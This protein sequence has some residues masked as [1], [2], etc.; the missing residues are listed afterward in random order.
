MDDK[1]HP[2]N[3]REMLITDTVIGLVGYAITARMSSAPLLTSL[4]GN[5]VFSH[6][7]GTLAHISLVW[8]IPKISHWKR[9]PRWTG[10]SLILALDATVGCVIAAFVLYLLGYYGIGSVWPQFQQAYTVSLVITLI[11]GLTGAITDSLR[12]R[13]EWA[14]RQRE[15]AMQLATEARL[16]SLESKIHPHFLFN[17]LNSISSL[18]REDPDHAERLIERMAALLRF[19][20]DATQLGLVTL[21]QEMDIVRGYLEIEKAR[22]GKRLQYSLEMPPDAAALMVPPLSIQTLVENSVKY[23]IAPRR[24][25]GAIAV[26]ATA[27]DGKLDI[28][29]RDGGPGVDLRS[30]P[31]GHGIDLLQSRLDVL[32]AGAASLRAEGSTL[33]LSLPCSAPTLSTMKS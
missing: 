20:L 1:P 6:S 14:T 21:A 23:A 28:S 29:I 30:A 8:A 25:G 5:Q 32:Y 24:E 10:I 12:T 9:L 27:T 26:V 22:F 33:T 13:L 31:P 2:V 18:V 19:S 15:R 11:F 17:A 7:I 4:V 3:I 16:S